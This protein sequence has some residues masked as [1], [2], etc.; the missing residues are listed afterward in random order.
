MLCFSEYLEGSAAF[1]RSVSAQ[2]TDA[3]IVEALNAWIASVAFC[4]SFHA[5]VHAGNL[6]VL[7]DGRLA[8]ID[9]GCVPSF[10]R[11]FDALA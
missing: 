9:F 7:Y 6:F 3:L 1:K 4:D 11:S 8:F 10:L 5:D 2:S